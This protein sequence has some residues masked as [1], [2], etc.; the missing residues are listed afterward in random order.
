MAPVPVAGR[1]YDRNASCQSSHPC[2][3]SQAHGLRTDTLSESRVLGS[4]SFLSAVSVL[5]GRHLYDAEHAW[6]GRWL[7]V[8]RRCRV[9]T[10]T[11]QRPVI[12]MLPRRM[13]TCP[14]VW[15]SHTRAREY[16]PARAGF[17]S[18]LAYRSVILGRKCRTWNGA[19]LL[20]PFSMHHHTM[21]RAEGTATANTVHHIVSFVLSILQR[22]LLTSE[23]G[24]HSASSQYSSV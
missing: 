10:S 15:S 7:D 3:P 2:R 14:S 16:I 18:A 11:A 4:A 19:T 24:S 23:P 22:L 13:H 8:E 17:K 21:A 1:L 9:D 6:P 12:S 5:G 20:K